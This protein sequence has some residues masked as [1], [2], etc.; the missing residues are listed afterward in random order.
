MDRNRDRLSSGAQSSSPRK[1]VPR[2]PLLR[3]PLGRLSAGH[4]EPGSR[5]YELAGRSRFDGRASAGQIIV[6]IE[7]GAE[8]LH[9]DSCLFTGRA[10]QD[11][12]KGS[13]GRD[14]GRS[15]L[16]PPV[17]KCSIGRR[18]SRELRAEGPN[19]IE[20]RLSIQGPCDTAKPAM[21]IKGEWEEHAWEADTL[22][23]EILP[24]GRA[25]SLAS[26]HHPFNVA[27]PPCAHGQPSRIAS[28][29]CAGAANLP[30]WNPRR[31][32]VPVRP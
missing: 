7:Q 6:G 18:A 30:R 31:R 21:R 27:G 20:M 17:N 4:L 8:S 23:T 16:V 11:G 13:L 32:P 15:R 26:A 29:A 19:S 2:G 24:L 3:R 9:Q 1:S 10:H 22:P 28:G 12:R 5:S 25:R 14:Q